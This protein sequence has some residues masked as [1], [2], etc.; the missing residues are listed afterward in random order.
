MRKPF[1]I[2]GKLVVA[3]LSVAGTGLLILEGLLIWH[4]EYRIGLPDKDKLATLSSTAPACSVSDRRTYVPLAEIP[5]LVRQAAIAYE[6]PEFYERLSLNPLIEF[7]A[8]MAF[9]RR[10]QPSG[11]TTSVTMCLISLSPECCRGIDWH[12]GNIVLMGRIAQI[13]SRDRILE[14][15]LNESYLGRASYGVGA[16]SMAYFDKPLG[17]LSVDEIA[18]ITALPRAPA[19]LGRR[20]DIA[21][22]RRNVVIDRLSKANIIS[23]TEATTARARPLQF[24]EPSP[25]NE[26]QQRKL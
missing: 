2:I 9:N 5:P 1:I 13:L 11:I 22:D 19:L 26:S 10:P 6:E 15:Y 14:I 24:R 20:N 23:E 18:L 17:L 21:R 25:D 4:Y 3:L 7:G 8:A 16:A 12:I